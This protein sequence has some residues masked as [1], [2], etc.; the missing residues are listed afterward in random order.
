[1]DM[2]KLI[3]RINVLARKKKAEGLTEEEKVEQQKLRAQ[4][5]EIFRNNFKN[6]LDSVKIVD[7][8]DGEMK[9]IN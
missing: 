7:E 2:E 3:A 4:Y 8:V 9:I 5:L 1:M 6:Q